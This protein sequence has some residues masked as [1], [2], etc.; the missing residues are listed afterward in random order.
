[1]GAFS[2]ETKGGRR[3]HPPKVLRADLKINKKEKLFALKSALA[4]VAS[5]EMIKKK[6]SSLQNTDVKIKLPMIVDEKIVTLK[7]KEFFESL[8][9]M[10]G[11]NVFQIAIQKKA[12]RA[13]I[14]KMRNRKYKK[15]AGLLLVI[16][17][18]QEMKISGVDVLKVKELELGDLAM[19]GARLVM[20][21]ESA[22][23]DLEAKVSGKKQEQAKEEDNKVKKQKEMKK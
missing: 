12:V 7:A 4:M 20:F 16:G 3:A 14:G 15:N 5:I 2:P 22:V 9:K 10:L 1:M 13:G 23:K 8:N 18:N 11:E 6:Y 17:N 19:N 21:T